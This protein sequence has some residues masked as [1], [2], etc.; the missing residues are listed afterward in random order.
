MPRFLYLACLGVLAFRSLSEAEAAPKPKCP[1]TGIQ[2]KIAELKAKPKA[3]PAYEVWAYKYQGHKVYLVTADC[4]DQYSTLYDECMQVL[5]APSGGFTGRG[6]GHCPQFAQEATD[7][8]LVWRD[9]R[10]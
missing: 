5:C 3:N 6:D 8:K 1:P 9:P 4:C 7:K 2:A 10:K